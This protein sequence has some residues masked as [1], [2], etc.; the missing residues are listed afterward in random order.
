MAEKYLCSCSHVRTPKFQLAAEQPSTGECCCCCCYVTSVESDS[1]GPHRLQPTSL[2]RPWDSPGKNTGVG[3]HFLLQCMK[4]KSEVAQSYPTRSDPMDY[5]PWD[6]PGRSTG[7][8]CHCLPQLS[9][10]ECCIQANKD[11]PYS[12]AKAKAQQDGRSGWIMFRIKP[13]TYQRRSEGTKHLVCTRT[14]GNEQWPPQDP[15]PHL[16]LSVWVSLQRH[17]SAVAC[18]GDR[19]SGCSRPERHRVGHKFSR[20][21]SP[22]APPERSQA[23]NPQTGEQLYQ[24]CSRTAAKVLRPT[25]D[26]PAWRSGEVLRTCRGFEYRNSIGL[27]KQTLGGHSKTLCAPEPKRKKQWPHKRLSQTYLWMFW[28]LWGRRA[29]TV[30]CCGVR[31]TDYNSPGSRA[32]LA[33]VLLKEVT[34]TVIT[35]TIVWPQENYRDL[36]LPHPLA[37]IWIIDLQSIASPT[38]ARP[39]YLHSQSLL[40][41][42]FQSLLS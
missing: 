27:G 2:P 26:F 20:R 29:W 31:G 41:G 10:G 25:I 23:D 19:G 35:P 22:L 42:S 7:V 39:S 28:S 38:R 15:E 8:G 17:R 14:Q 40:A 36:R 16:P 32:V 13:H 30:A 34:I 1:V 11:T 21:R 18:R 33:Y 4:V 24:R 12:R 9:T 3:C 5:C 6:F 37:E